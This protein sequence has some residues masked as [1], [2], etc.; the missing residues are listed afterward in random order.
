MYH[1]LEASLGAH[2]CQTPK[3]IT[4]KVL[5]VEEV[6]VFRNEMWNIYTQ[7]YQVDQAAFFDRFATNDYYAIY[8]KENATIGFTAFR[9]RPIQIGDKT[10]RTFYLGQSVLQ[11]EFRG[12]SLIP[13]TCVQL[14]I[15]HF[16]QHPFTPIYVWCDALTYKP[17]LFICQRFT[18]LLSFS[19]SNCSSKNRGLD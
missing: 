9:I 3:R 11:K 16:L 4:S 14:S 12:Q 1:L 7:Y 2:Q 13:K 19:E 10:Y 18:T 15:K 8:K 5:K 6:L 17:Y